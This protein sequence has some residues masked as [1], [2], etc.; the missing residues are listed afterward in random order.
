MTSTAMVFVTFEVW[1]V[2]I[3]Q[4]LNYDPNATQD[5]GSCIDIVEGCT[6]MCRNYNPNAN[7]DESCDF[8]SCIGV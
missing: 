3:Y 4:A 6:N 1:V 7:V 2:M 5:D 8:E